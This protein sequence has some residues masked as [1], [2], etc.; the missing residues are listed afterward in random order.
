M[1]KDYKAKITVR[2]I[3]AF[4]VYLFLNDVLSEDVNLKKKTKQKKTKLG[5]VQVSCDQSRRRGGSQNDHFRSQRGG[6]G[7]TANYHLITIWTGEQGC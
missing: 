5:A 1:F 2:Y 6:R 3:Y 4:I 7:N